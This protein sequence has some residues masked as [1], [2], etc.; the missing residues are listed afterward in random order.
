MTKWIT[1][2]AAVLAALA[3]AIPAGAQGH[4]RYADVLG[5]RAEAGAALS[6]RIES[7]RV[8]GERAEVG[9]AASDRIEGARA[10]PRMLGEQ[11]EAGTA[12]SDR[13]EQVRVRRGMEV[14]LTTRIE[15]LDDLIAADRPL[16][17]GVQDGFDWVAAGSGAGATL[18]LVLG[19]FGIA[20]VR[21]GRPTVTEAA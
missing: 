10:R 2:L 3:F 17:T 16:A 6:D 9:I 15:A 18:V 11:A 20:F 5:E 19:A 8:L 1:C 4:A 14:A 21:R 7:A 12:L 13:I